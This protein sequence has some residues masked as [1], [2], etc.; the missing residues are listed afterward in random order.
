MCFLDTNEPVGT[1]FCIFYVLGNGENGGYGLHFL[2]E[3]EE[4]VSGS[5]FGAA[6]R[7]RSEVTDVPDEGKV[8]AVVGVD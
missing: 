1:I 6:A 2:G 5:F 8:R 4:W 3:G 7:V